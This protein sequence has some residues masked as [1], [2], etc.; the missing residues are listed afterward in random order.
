LMDILQT[1]NTFDMFLFVFGGF[2]LVVC[3]P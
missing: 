1:W 2:V 3:Q